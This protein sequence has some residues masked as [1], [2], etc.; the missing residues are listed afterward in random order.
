MLVLAWND[1][2]PL[3]SSNYSFAV[4]HT[5]GVI[6]LD[7]STNNG[8]YLVHSMPNFPNIT[9][10]QIDPTVPNTAKKYG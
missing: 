7:L 10:G 3:D 8:F 1:G 9:N 4:G 2:N 6:V 5:K